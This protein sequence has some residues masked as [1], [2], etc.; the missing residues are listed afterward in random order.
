MHVGRGTVKGGKWKEEVGKEER[1]KSRKSVRQA[2]AK[3]YL[4]VHFDLR[5]CPSSFETRESGEVETRVLQVSIIMFAAR[6]RCEAFVPS[7]SCA[8]GARRG[9][10]R[11]AACERGAGRTSGA[12]VVAS[13]VCVLASHAS[14]ARRAL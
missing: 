5:V 4:S 9:W 7:C 11:G 2:S 6:N 8:D 10:T 14:I 1:E 13:R 3:P 12:L